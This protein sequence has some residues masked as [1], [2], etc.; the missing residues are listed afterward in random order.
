MS[1]PDIIDGLLA[2]I[3]AQ[4]SGLATVQEAWFA[5]P[6]DDF[7]SQT[8]AALPY[9][10]EDSAEGG[11]ET[12]RP[13]Q[14]ISLTY[15]IWLVCERADFRAQRNALRQA[16][17]GHVF[18]QHHEPMAY[19]GGQTTDIRGHLIWW[20]EFWTVDTWLRGQA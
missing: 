13:V 4:A 11:I 15:G 17:M 9:L 5:S 2:R 8:P 12:L 20:R 3:S 6:I 7:R 14:R 19:R 1:D 16:L 10:A 18:T